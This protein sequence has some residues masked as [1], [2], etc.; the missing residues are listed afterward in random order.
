MKTQTI[1][2]PRGNNVGQAVKD[3]LTKQGIYSKVKVIFNSITR[4][5]KTRTIA[6]VITYTWF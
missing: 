3:A 2:V 4:N 5:T 6:V 1:L